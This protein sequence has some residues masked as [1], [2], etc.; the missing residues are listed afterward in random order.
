M[1]HKLREVRVQHD[2]EQYIHVEVE[3]KHPELKDWES[4]VARVLFSDKALS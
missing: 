1:L 4:F 3:L 2:V